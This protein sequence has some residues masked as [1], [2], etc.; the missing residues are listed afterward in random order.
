MKKLSKINHITKVTG[1]RKDNAKD[2]LC[3]SEREG[4]GEWTLITSL[5][6]EISLK[7]FGFKV[8]KNEGGKRI[9]NIHSDEDKN[10]IISF[11]KGS[12]YLTR[13]SLLGN[14]DEQEEEGL[15]VKVLEV[16]SEVLEL[17]D[18]VVVLKNVLESDGE[19]LLERV[20]TVLKE[21]FGV[22]ES[23]RRDE[24]D[25]WNQFCLDTKE[26]VQNDWLLGSF[27]VGSPS[28]SSSVSTSSTT[29]SS[30]SISTELKSKLIL[31]LHRLSEDLTLKTKTQSSS[32]KLVDKLI[33]P[34]VR[35]MG[36][37]E[38]E[39]CYIRKG[40]GERIR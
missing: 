15:G 21:I 6:Q 35:A 14:S 28:C 17:E 7:N 12:R 20:G 27:L 3:Y 10:L 24:D 22:D 11:E 36:W 18:F 38:W 37:K 19:V 5:A 39:D 26:D 30:T 23:Q 25:E 31:A 16:I 33:L 9:S 34:L 13:F 32:F 8:P 29:T 1:M 40:V 4:G 2:L